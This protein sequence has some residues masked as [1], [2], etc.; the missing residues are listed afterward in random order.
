MSRHRWGAKTLVTPNKSE[1]ECL[2]GCGI[3][4]VSRRESEGGRGVYWTEFWRGLDRIECDGT[5]PCRGSA[6]AIAYDARN[7]PL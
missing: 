3:V 1:C 2:N 5:P 7:Y 6:R 4:K